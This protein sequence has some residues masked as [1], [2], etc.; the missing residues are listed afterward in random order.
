[1]TVSG[2]TYSGYWG[3]Q[4]T[5]TLTV[6]VNNYVQPPT[7][8]YNTCAVTGVVTNIGQNSATLNGLVSNSSTYNGN[9][10]FEYGT[11]VTLG[12]Q[13]SARSIGSSTTFSET[14]SG[15]S[16]KTIYFYRLVSNCNNTI[17]K[18]SIEIFQ[19]SGTTTTTTTIIRQGTTVVGT[20]S[21]IMLKIENRYQSFRV[22]DN[23][24]YTITYKNISNRTLTHPVLQV[25]LPKGVAFLNSSRGTYS[26]DTYT[27]TVSLEDL[28]SNV[29]GVVYVQGRVDSID[30]GNAQIVTTALLVYTARNGAQENAMAYV[31]N[32]PI[33]TSGFGLGAAALFGSMFGMGIVGWLLILILILLAILLFRKIYR[34]QN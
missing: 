31:L 16:P 21:P 29:E 22:G 32:N 10:Y 26:S 25:I 11:D 23:V 2:S 13:T 33:L 8:I 28:V 9:T 4:D 5:R 15:L 19:T 30:S 3:G 7:P 27:V 34:R 24:D 1:M 14:I 18:G 17:S 6:Y 20:A 12:S